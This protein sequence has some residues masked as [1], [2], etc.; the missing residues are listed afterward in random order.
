[1][2]RSKS[3]NEVLTLEK[4]GTL[5]DGHVKN[6]LRLLLQVEVNGIADNAYDLAIELRPAL[7]IHSRAE[8]LILPEEVPGKALVDDNDAWS[9]GTV[10]GRESSAYDDALSQR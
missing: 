7:D 10:E 9:I 4:A 6:P 2:S 8:G 5:R 3:K 1:M